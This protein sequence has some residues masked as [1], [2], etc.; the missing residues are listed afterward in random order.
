MSQRIPR[1]HWDRWIRFRGLIDTAE[2]A[3]AVSL[4]PLNLL[5]RFHWDR[6]IRFRGLI[7]I[8]EAK[9]IIR[10]F[11]LVLWIPRSNWNHRSRFRGLIATA[12]A[13]S[14]AK[15]AFAVS[16]KPPNPLPR[17]YCNRGSGFCSLIETAEAD[18]FKQ[19]SRISWRFRSHMRNCFSPWIRDLGGV[20]WWKN[21]GS[22]ISWHC[23]FNG[24]FMKNCY[25]KKNT[26]ITKDLQHLDRFI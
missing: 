6:Q 11:V 12:E 22:K 3:S 7:E 26:K 19:L 4:R 23:P 17:P 8:V 5:P 13:A 2:S 14:A 24:G 20:D 9:L 18:N 10:S 16:L 25:L 21:R 15:A 1:S